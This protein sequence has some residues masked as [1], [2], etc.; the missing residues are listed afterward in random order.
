MNLLGVKCTWYLDYVRNEDYN[1]W[2]FNALKLQRE[3]QLNSAT[4]AQRRA[5]EREIGKLHKR[6]INERKR[7]KHPDQ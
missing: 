5:G 2:E 3:Q 6:I 4:L 1:S 7:Q